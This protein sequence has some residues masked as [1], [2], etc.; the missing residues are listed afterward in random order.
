MDKK[1]YQTIYGLQKIQFRFKH[2]QV[3]SKEVEKDISCKR[4][5]KES[6]DGYVCTRQKKHLVKNGNKRH[7]SMYKMI[8][9]SV[10]QKKYFK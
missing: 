6:K 2:I 10:L 3:E 1:E 4:Q 8:E 5:P 9:E 7:K